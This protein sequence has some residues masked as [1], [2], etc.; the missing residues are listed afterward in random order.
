MDIPE[1]G[2]FICKEGEDPTHVGTMVYLDGKPIGGIQKFSV[3]I[4]AEKL[5]PIIRLEIIPVGGLTVATHFGPPKYQP[6]EQDLVFRSSVSPEE[7]L[8][9]HTRQEEKPEIL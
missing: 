3:E 4:D 2:W 7:V 5:L 9:S 8:E 6:I 1:K